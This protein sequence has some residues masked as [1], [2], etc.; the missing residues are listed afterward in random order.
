MLQ[1][2]SSRWKRDGCVRLERNIYVCTVAQS[3]WRKRDGRDSRRVR[4][5]V[6]VVE[7]VKETL[8]QAGQEEREKLGVIG[9]RV[10]GE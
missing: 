5:G 2:R 1:E 8:L 7:T 6:R 3:S 4:R 10:E 9:I